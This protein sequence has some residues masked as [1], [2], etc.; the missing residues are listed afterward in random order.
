MDAR[1]PPK[2]RV[3]WSQAKAKLSGFDRAGLMALLQDLYAASKETQAFLHAR[4][5]LGENPLVPCKQV[6]AGSLRPDWNKSASVATAKKA[7]SAFGKAN[8]RA[9]DTAELM[10]FF[11]EQAAGY[12]RDVG[13]QDESHF[14]GLV[15]MYERAK[16]N[17]TARPR[18]RAL[19]RRRLRSL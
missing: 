13:L 18:A 5:A 3:A 14:A 19:P 2:P 15:R 10:I 7:I 17:R 1:K 9:E 6:I 12:V 4:F 11:C 16:K 8:G